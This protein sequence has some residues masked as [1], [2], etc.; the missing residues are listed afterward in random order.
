M[1]RRSLWIAAALAI[2]AL[3]FGFAWDYLDRDSIPHQSIQYALKEF[4]QAIYQYH[5]KT[6]AWPQRCEDFAGTE[7][8]QA[9]RYWRQMATVMVIVPHAELKDDPMENRT[10]VIAYYRGGLY[11]KMGRVWVCWGDLRTEYVTVEE[12]GRMGILRAE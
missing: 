7:L 11:S 9:L 12:L 3:A 2:A 1:W 4:G 6:G 10:A 5:Q 8:P